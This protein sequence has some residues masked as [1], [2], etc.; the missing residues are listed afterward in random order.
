MSIK[1][2][3]LQECTENA[4]GEHVGRLCQTVL[5]ALD[6]APKRLRLLMRNVNILI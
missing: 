6:L 2:M 1:E 5:T 4:D 3:N